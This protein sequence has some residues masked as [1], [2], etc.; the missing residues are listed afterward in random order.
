MNTD[1]HSQTAREQRLQEALVAC[2]EAAESGRSPDRAAL[3]A[4]YPD[5][6]AEI[7]EFLT[8]RE[9]LDRV[10]A[11]LRQAAN[12]GGEAPSAEARTGPTVRYF[13][14]YE[15]L[16][17][18][19]RGGMGVVYRA[20]QKSLNRIVALKMI[21]TGQFASPA[22]VA[23]FHAEAEAAANLDHP[24]IVP[25]YE[26]GEHQGHHYFSMKLIEGGSL[27]QHLGRFHAD[28]RAAA[29]LVATV[30]RA[31]QHA[32][33]H[34][35]LH[36]DLKPGNILLDARGEPH[37]TDF[38]L[39]KRVEGGRPPTQSGALVGTPGYMAPEQATGRK[40]LTTAAD[41]YGLGAILYELLTGRPPFR[42]ATA[43]DTLLQAM[44]REPDRPSSWSARV[45]RDLETVC[46]KC[47]EKDP[48]RRYGSAEALADDLERWLRGEPILARRSTAWERTTKWVR[49]RPALAA[50]LATSVVALVALLVSSGLF[51]LQLQAAL[52]RTRRQEQQ[53]AELTEAADREKKLAEQRRWQALLTE[54]RAARL[55]GGRWPSLAAIAEAARLRTAPELRQEAILTLTSPGLRIVSSLGPR[56]LMVGGEG[57]YLQFS[58]DGRLLASSESLL[59][60]AEPR[61]VEGIK[62]WDVASG[63]CVGQ[64]EAGYYGGCFAWNPTRPVLAL[65]RYNQD[66]V[67]L[68]DAAAGKVIE[69]LK[70][71]PPV[72][73]SPDG[74]LLAVGAARKVRVWDLAGHRELPFTAD[75]H[76][77][78][79]PTA[80][81]L[82]VLS[83]GRLRLW[84]VRSGEEK[85]V[86]PQG[87][88]AQVWSDDARLAG[89]RRAAEPER[90]PVTVWDLLAGQERAT[91]PDPGDLPRH[92]HSAVPLSPTAA[93]AVA[94]DPAEPY[95]AWLLDLT[96]GK[97]RGRLLIPGFA[98]TALYRGVFNA[99]GSLLAAMDAEQGNV[100]LWDTN[101]GQ[102][103][104]TLSEQRC[105]AWSPD[106]RYL[107]VFATGWFEPEGTVPRHGG[108]DEHIRVY[109]IAAPA[110]SCRVTAAVG[111]LTFG[112]GGKLLL[113]PGSAWQVGRERGQVVL[114]PGPSR[115]DA[116]GTYYAAPTGQLWAMLS[117]SEVK[118]PAALT[119]TQLAPRQRKVVL[120]ARNEAGAPMNLIVSPDGNAVL[121]VWQRHI[122][123]P[124]STSWSNK[125]QA[126]LWDVSGDPAVKR[127]EQPL[128]GFSTQAGCFSPDGRTVAV[129]DSHTIVL[130]DSR[131]GKARP[132][133]NVLTVEQTPNHSRI[134]NVKEVCFSPDGRQLF[135][136]A[137]GG[138]VGVVDVAEGKRTGWWTGHR[139]D[140]LCV[141]VSPDGR[142]VASG[143]EDHTVRLWDA[144]TGR[145]LAYWGGHEAK[146]T[147]V[148]FSPDSTALV[149]GGGN[150]ICKFWDL[151]ALRKGLAELG[152]DW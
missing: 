119:L 33:L 26:V 125:N 11:P 95:S 132:L 118:P 82:V 14:D 71:G 136:A 24:N 37:V 145:E 44:E 18:V 70:G 126:E 69:E 142:T 80:D 67:R 105:P 91:L 144:A 76:P 130:C 35:V 146:V 102:L 40:G 57:P 34:G 113:A 25:I 103:L 75:G 123:F 106:G 96:H 17:E 127:W 50:L 27:A 41:V 22:E 115:L 84:T 52:E 59:S 112:D 58:G 120:P 19:A 8:D 100:R 107:A 47:L 15:L 36:R 7:E 152:L 114:R 92:Y 20:R 128:S 16:E 28:P 148:A 124:G 98:G 10:A 151:P 88:V 79:F 38:G 55:A 74:K 135:C 31:V 87:T 133:Q 122:P 62:V 109:E 134:Y 108:T 111:A 48:H 147:A 66:T 9:H 51:T 90:G 121:L 99:T 129:W 46:L 149:S 6:A 54:A 4:R 65:T 139:G 94:Q 29:R 30:A 42:G 117:G 104:Q 45:D 61:S 68:W 1:T 137:E 13:G 101:T 77:I 81:D 49:R 53:A 143:G 116:V 43:L 93:L 3:L 21:L 86:T 110:P 140:C 12:A 131:M 150:G 141:A 23:R 72:C 78:A 56:N 39:A 89:V 73:F 63:K 83:G 64:A 138:A 60:E 2:L 85:F 32:H 97:A 5:C